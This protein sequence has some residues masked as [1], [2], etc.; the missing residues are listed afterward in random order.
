MQCEW[1]TPPEIIELVKEVLGHVDVDPA[2]NLI[3]QELIQANIFYTKEDDGLKFSWEGR[4]WCNPPYSAKLIKQ[5]TK[6]FAEE[7][8]C[9]HMT[10]GIIL[11]NSGTDTQWNQNIVGGIQAYTI[12]RISFMQPDGTRK[13]TGSRGQC[14]TY[15]GKNPE[16]FIEVF[17]R[18]GFCWVP[19]L[20]LMH[21]FSTM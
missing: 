17:T 5:F 19:N 20:A 7:Y 4:V 9:G 3:A 11:T 21:S 6:K 1:Y 2:S 15:F 12:G 8:E 14:F 18:N 16:K 13:A 10:E